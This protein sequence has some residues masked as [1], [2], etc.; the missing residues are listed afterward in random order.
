MTGM[1][2]YYRSIVTMA[3]SRIVSKILV[4]NCKFLVPNLYLAPLFGVTPSEF[5]SRL[6]WETRMMG[7]PGDEKSLMVCL[8]VTAF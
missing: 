4:E 2:F 5:H 8:A 3:I 1:G 6:L 7:P